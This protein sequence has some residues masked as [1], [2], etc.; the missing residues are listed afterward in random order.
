MNSPPGGFVFLHRGREDLGSHGRRSP[1][2]SRP[3]PPPHL[4]SRWKEQ[5]QDNETALD[6]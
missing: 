3:P 6:Q 1:Q 5:L 2:A 4:S